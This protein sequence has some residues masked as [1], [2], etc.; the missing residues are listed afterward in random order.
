MATETVSDNAMVTSATDCSDGRIPDFFI[1]GHPKCGTT[2]LYEMLKQHPQ[3]HMPVKEP[4]FFVMEQVEAGTQQVQAGTG[5]SSRS[6]SQP[7]G[8][9]PRQSPDARQAPRWRPR[10]L[11]G[12]RALFAG[13]RPG[14]RVG[15]ATPAYLRSPVVPARIAALR[16]D[17]RIIAILREPASFLR[18][19]HLMSVRGY[20][21][22]EKDFRKAL[23]LEQQRR[24][25]RQIPRT[26]RAPKDHLLYMDHV[27]YVEQLRRYH[28]AF[29]PEQVLVL[30]YE[31][32]RRDNEAAVRN[33]LRFLELDDGASFETVQTHSSRE[34]RLGRL[35]KL[36]K[37]R[38]IAVRNASVGGPLSRTARA[39][40]P[41]P[42]RGGLRSSWRRVA[43]GEPP[44]ADEELMREL[45]RRLKPEVQALSEYLDRDLEPVGL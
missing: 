13:A 35:H 42:L 16:P 45:R 28:A 9:R 38:R 43:Y 8:R 20:Y 10:T 24:A 37:L 34:L 39:L 5:A 41:A 6:G 23:A 30:I 22:T 1:V 29:P 19:F 36:A 21:E 2:A 17:A 12:Y 40:T 7:S 14:Q 31:D 25:G 27:R 4:R 32:F 26:S 44:A 15:E 33:V 18:S 11:D 3:I